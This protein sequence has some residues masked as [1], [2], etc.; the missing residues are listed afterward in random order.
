MEFQISWHH[1]MVIWMLTL[2]LLLLLCVRFIAL[3]PLIPHAL[4]S[5]PSRP[6]VRIGCNLFL[7]YSQSAPIDRMWCALHRQTRTNKHTH[8]HK[9]FHVLFIRKLTPGYDRFEYRQNI[10]LACFM[11]DHNSH[12][13]CLDVIPK[14]PHAPALSMPRLVRCPR[15]NRQS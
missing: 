15:W 14:R 7:A 6:I 2:Q 12:H 13:N 5:S 1:F 4:C 11:A 3:C 10:S 9:C 8:T